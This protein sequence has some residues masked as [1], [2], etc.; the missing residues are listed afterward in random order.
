MSF[1]QIKRLIDAAQGCEPADVVIRNCTVVDVFAEDYLNRDLLIVEDKIAA[2]VD[3]GEGQ[4]KQ[5]IDADGAF[6]VPGLIESHMHVESTL[7]SLTEVARLIVPRG[8]TT[9]IIDPHEIANVLGIEG[10][11]LLL[12]SVQDLPLK[13]LIQIPS[14][15][16]TAPG[17]ETTGG[18]IDLEDIRE[19]L[20]WS[21]VVA[22]GELD[23]SKV[24]PPRPEYIARVEMAQAEGVITCGH[25]ADLSGR[26]LMAY[27]STG[28]ADDHECVSVEEI[29]ERVRAGMRVN[30][31]EGTSER[32]LETLVRAVTVHGVPARRLMHCTD[33]KQ[34]ID[35]ME[36][37]H[38]DHN[39]RWGI[40]CGLTPMQS[41]QMA[42]INPSEHFHLESR[43]G[44]LTPGRHADLFLC[45]DL[46]ALEADTVI[47]DGKVVAENG[48]LMQQPSA[49]TYPDWA[50]S[51]MHLGKQLKRED[52][53]IHAPD[54]QNEVTAK[55]I[56]VIPDLAID[57]MI[58]EKMDV[59]QGEVTADRDRDLFKIAVVDRHKASG[60]VGL[61][62][63]QGFGFKQ[64]AIGST[65]C[66]DNHNLI[67]V[68][69]DG[70]EMAHCA[71]LIA[72]M[73]GGFAL[74]QAGKV[75]AKLPLPLAGIMSQAAFEQVAEELAQMRRAAR[76]MGITLD[77]PFMK[78]SILALPTVPEVGLT[79]MG[80]VDVRKH[81]IVPLFCVS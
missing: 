9:I 12:D 61:G 11:R 77:T 5:V 73:G 31:R 39:V 55:V 69:S 52:F 19:M 42:T 7:V 13:V 25:A 59:V 51:T 10:I 78:L 62:L 81:A 6:A 33:D 47:V 44:S 54:N 36:E 43:I 34:V 14:R 53:T 24:L 28:L 8:V 38:I 70:D 63:I 27:A 66:H 46:Q 71:N 60:R 23:P 45:R 35:L 75:L 58:F 40:E 1:R 68:G 17:I 65:V 64:G 80:L 22:L 20:S 48:G 18:E 56:K 32:D 29:I 21:E 41:I 2:L 16:P 67:L 4:G 30:I 57:E 26:E 15:V 72:T 74:V 50:L 76:D 79:D 49:P 37:G 3:P